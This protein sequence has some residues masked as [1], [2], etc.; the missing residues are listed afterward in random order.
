MT[1]SQV[2]AKAWYYARYERRA[3]VR[4]LIVNAT[5]SKERLGLDGDERLHLKDGSMLLF[6]KLAD[7]YIV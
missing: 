1:S 3:E 7:E 2:L 4:R 6:R 5:V